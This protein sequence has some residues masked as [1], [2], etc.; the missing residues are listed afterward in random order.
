MATATA[1]MTATDRAGLPEPA[2]TCPIPM[3]QIGR[4]EGVN[5]R[6]VNAAWVRRQM[7]EFSPAVLGVLA[8]SHR[9]DGTYVVLDGQ[10]RLA[11]AKACGYGPDIKCSVYEGLDR[12][13]EALL[14]EKLNDDRTLRPGYIFL[15]RVTQENPVAMAILATAER[16]GWRIGVDSGL[17]V[18]T[19]VTTL[20]TI[21]SSGQ[22]RWPDDPPFVLANT[23]QSITLAWQQAPK[24]QDRALISGIGAL[25]VK[26]GLAIDV[27][28]MATQLATFGQPL[29]LLQKARGRQGYEGG[30]VA[31]SVSVLVTDGYNKGAP[32]GRKLPAFK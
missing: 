32:R 30:S 20:E 7:G 29:D 3:D 31:K 4:D 26:R 25:Y 10:N 11:L 1:T 15:A 28:T 17:G 9:P 23:L 13:Q 27:Q 8:V 21:W 16:A 19:A 12:K 5:T 24:A 18:I 2:E 6:P 22:N 14:F